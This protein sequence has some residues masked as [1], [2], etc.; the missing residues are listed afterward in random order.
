MA[1]PRSL[2][3]STV[4]PAPRGATGRSERK[5]AG[6]GKR[7]RN[8][9]H[10]QVQWE[11]D[12]SDDSDQDE[13]AARPAV[14]IP[15][16]RG[17]KRPRSLEV[18]CASPASSK[19]DAPTRS[20][21]G[22][23]LTTEQRTGRENRDMADGSSDNHDE[24]AAAGDDA[25]GSEASAIAGMGDVMAKILAQKLDG[26]KQVIVLY[27]VMW[28][29]S[30]V[31]GFTRANGPTRATSCTACV[32]S[33]RNSNQAAEILKKNQWSRFANSIVKTRTWCCPLC[34]DG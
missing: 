16:S 12:K 14:V 30:R 29:G 33:A 31:Q 7:K 9:G 5:K 1:G 32:T 2:S 8:E 34:V 19:I 10:R 4:V 3:K 13:Q 20:V 26:L 21:V 11:H 28:K 24:S 27:S 25:D 15:A 17:K 18:V 6:K 22:A 23:P